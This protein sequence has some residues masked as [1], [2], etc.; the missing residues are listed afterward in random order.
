MS[1]NVGGKKSYISCYLFEKQE[2]N[3]IY[4]VSLG[5]DVNL[6]VLALQSS[7]WYCHD[8]ESHLLQEESPII[9]ENG[10]VFCLLFGFVRIFWL[11]IG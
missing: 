4:I 1:Q 7:G 9:K 5:A 8:I 10:L 11:Y 3:G 2:K 6:I